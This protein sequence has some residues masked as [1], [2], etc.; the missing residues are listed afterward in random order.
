V[1][2]EWIRDLLEFDD[3]VGAE[4]TVL[5]ERVQRGVRGGGLE[6]GRLMLESERLIAHFQGLLLDALA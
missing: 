2:E 5:V 1:D 3:Q 6:H 4:D